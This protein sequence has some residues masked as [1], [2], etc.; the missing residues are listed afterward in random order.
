MGEFRESGAARNLRRLARESASPHVRPMTTSPVALLLVDVVSPF[1]FEGSEKLLPHAEAAAGPLA[2][3]AD[4]ARQS[5][6]PVIYANDNFANWSEDFDA[7]VERSTRA[8]APGREIVQRVRPGPDDYF[9]L[10]PKHSGFFQTPLES[11]LRQLGVRTLVIA[12]FATDIC[13]L[14]TAMDAAMR[15]VALVIP[16]DA[17]AAETDHAHR[18][19]LAHFRRVLHA[20][21]P[22]ASAVD[23]E[24]LAAEADGV[25]AE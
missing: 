24:A 1:E 5:G 20:Q 25:E 12:G 7:L 23:F 14:A 18:A 2:A 8:D 13:V 21:T 11:L 16:Q 3:L 6:V 10:K 15:D 9:V 22:P 17:S 4:R 19:A